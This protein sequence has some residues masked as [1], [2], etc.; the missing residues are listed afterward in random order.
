MVIVF[1][2]LSAFGASTV[3]AD[4]TDRM[5]VTNNITHSQFENDA[6]QQETTNETSSVSFSEIN[7]NDT[8][9]PDTEVTI[10][11]IISNNGNGA[12]SLTVVFVV[13]NEQQDEESI[14]INSNEERQFEFIWSTPN[15]EGS[16][17]LEFAVKDADEPRKE[18][19]VTVDSEVS[20]NIQLEIADIE[21]PVVEG[22][23]T[24][25]TATIITPESNGGLSEVEIELRVTGA[26]IDNRTE[27]IRESE[28]DV[29]FTWVPEVSHVGSPTI[30]IASDQ[31][32]ES[33]E[34]QIDVA[35]QEPSQ[36][37]VTILDVKESVLTNELFTVE[38]DVENTGA[39]VGEQ[40]V[41]LEAAGEEVD[42]TTVPLN[43]GESTQVNLTWDIGEDAAGTHTL[44][45]QSDTDNDSQQVVIE[46][47]ES[48]L[49]TIFGLVLPLLILSVGLFGIGVVASPWVR[50]RIGPAIPF[51]STTDSTEETESSDASALVDV[52]S[53]LYGVPQVGQKPRIDHSESNHD[54]ENQSD[55]DPTKCKQD[56][57]EDIEDGQ[58]INRRYQ[59]S[60]GQ[61]LENN[62]DQVLFSHNVQTSGKFTE[63]LNKA[64]QIAIN[65]NDPPS[66]PGQGK[67]L[68]DRLETVENSTRYLDE[69]GE[70]L[71]KTLIA[72]V[73]N[74]SSAEQVT[75]E[76]ESTI[77]ELSNRSDRITELKDKVQ[78]ER[79]QKERFRDL[80]YELD[81][82]LNR[83]WIN[84]Y[85]DIQ[86]ADSVQPGELTRQA[87]NE[88]VVGE[89]T[90]RVAAQEIQ[91][92]V[93]RSSTSFGH[94]SSPHKF[95]KRVASATPRETT[96]VEDTLEE[97]AEKL[98]E[99]ERLVEY[100]WKNPKDIEYK[101]Q[102]V[103]N[104]CERV[105]DRHSLNTIENLAEQTYRQSETLQN[106]ALV[107]PTLIYERLSLLED[108][109]NSLGRDTESVDI[110]TTY[111]DQR[112]EDINNAIREID[113]IRSG[114]R[115]SRW[116]LELADEFR[117]LA[118][119]ASEKGD[120]KTAQ[121][122]LKA[123]YELVDHI[124][125]MYT[126]NDLVD[127]LSWAD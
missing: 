24:N 54:T 122:Y 14:S 81:Q 53:E 42:N 6:E 52:H 105:S 46:K 90:A 125:Q 55:P 57:L 107:E 87:R 96:E 58:I 43:P 36:F 20:E 25:I 117:G 60:S 74:E 67:E 118:R 34:Q 18:R 37:D 98:A 94:G 63:K 1:S 66:P 102:D 112:R 82:D 35:P 45:V 92:R 4:D 15:E 124:Y 93:D 65:H 10:S 51:I 113:N 64:L 123:E 95:I 71:L 106:G 33:A 31:A 68:A 28:T 26:F 70:S 56:I 16:Y 83:Q 101:H 77:D 126:N 2:A 120:E 79:R 76:V 3:G 91:S 48:L 86:V 116:Y 100:E 49:D 12:E 19:Q 21:H 85:S 80:L 44:V 121:A 23:E 111:I 13:D 114:H 75:Q 99:S 50:S 72:Y 9:S 61:T 22:E 109:L 84:K 39:T 89:Q 17:A 59:S 88:G 8:V 41:R 119:D 73:Q 115:I 103:M 7:I 104:A 47:S 97:T 38:A 62:V 5:V 11:G 127:I 108:L 78:E 32:E 110:D 40:V 29:K 27:E 30:Q 69:I